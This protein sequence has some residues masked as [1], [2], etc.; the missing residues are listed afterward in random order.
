[1]IFFSCD[2]LVLSSVLFPESGLV[3]EDPVLVLVP[4]LDPKS[5]GP[6]PIWLE[7]TRTGGSNCR[8]QV[9]APTPGW[10]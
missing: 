9:T 8:N 4:E 5:A 2:F 3:L 10:W 6:V 1:V 7:Q